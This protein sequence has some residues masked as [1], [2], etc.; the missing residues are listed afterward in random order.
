[1]YAI[2]LI[3]LIT[4]WIPHTAMNKLNPTSLL[5]T[6]LLATTLYNTANADDVKIIAANF[7]NDGGDHWSVKVTLQHS[8]TGWDH[9]ADSWRIVDNDGNLLGNRMLHHPH[10]N[11]QPFT[12]GLS[13]IKIPK[14]TTTIYIEAH[15]KIHGWTQNRQEVD[16]R[17]AI[18]GRLRVGIE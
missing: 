7:Y 11:E 18:D 13:G 2:L 3:F 16:L 17:N 14:E 9:Y 12:R 4:A 5:A 15:D 8:D 10:V 6:I 1:M